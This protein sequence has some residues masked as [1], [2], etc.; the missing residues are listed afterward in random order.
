MYHFI[1]F[2]SL[3]CGPPVLYDILKFHPF[4]PPHPMHSAWTDC[5]LSEG[6]IFIKLLLGS[7]PSPVYNHCL[8][9]WEALHTGPCLTP[10]VMPSH[11]IPPFHPPWYS[12]ASPSIQGPRLPWYDYLLGPGPTP[13]LYFLAV[14]TPRQRCWTVPGIP[15]HI[16]LTPG[17]YVIRSRIVQMYNFISSHL[18]LKALQ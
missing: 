17:I 16:P 8:Y 7:N 3:F 4:H 13:C 18:K 11:I 5:S 6:F 15:G 10:G 2:F 9:P 1:P 14:P 12:A